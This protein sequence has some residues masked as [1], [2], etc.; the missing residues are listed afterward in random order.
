MVW[1]VVFEGVVFFVLEAWFVAAAPSA[2]EA[3]ALAVA[4][5]VPPAP[6]PA[7]GVEGGIFGGRS[8]MS[9]VSRI[10]I[11]PWRAVRL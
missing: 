6:V 9:G 11:R 4:L 7:A 2:G 8:S 1:L 3:R 10:G 5:G